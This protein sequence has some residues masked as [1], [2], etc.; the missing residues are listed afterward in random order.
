MLSTVMVKLSGP[1]PCDL[2]QVDLTEYRGIMAPWNH[3]RSIV[4]QCGAL[5]LALLDPASDGKR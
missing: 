5:A 2:T 3:W 1:D 4:R